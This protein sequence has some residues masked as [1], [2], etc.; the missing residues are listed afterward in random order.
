MTPISPITEAV[1]EAAPPIPQRV[2]PTGML[3]ALGGILMFFTAL[4]SAWIVRKGLST[5]ALEA[6]LALPNGL[7]SLNT[8]ILLGSSAALEVARHEMRAGQ[9]EKFRLWWY[10]TTALGVLFLIGQLAVWRELARQGV[11][12]A[13]NPDAG[14]FYLL[15]GAHA[16]HLLG[17][18]IGLLFV[19]LK[20]LKQLTLRSA[21]RVS[22]MYWH[23]LTMIWVAIFAFLLFSAK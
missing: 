10:A 5:S 16:L 18:I 21:T 19:A 8:V 23:F 7:L 22:A 2:Y 1:R 3:V 11:Y 14:F 20:P 6:P 15:T 9:H 12:L 13:S 17:G 4:F